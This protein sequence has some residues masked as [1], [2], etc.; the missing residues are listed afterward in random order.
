MNYQ[1]YNFFLLYLLNINQRNC[2]IFLWFM[3]S[4]MR[5][6]LASN[7][8]NLMSFKISF[9]ICSSRL[10][11]PLPPPKL[12]ITTCNIVLPCLPPPS[13]RSV[14][15]LSLSY[16]FL[17]RRWLSALTTRSKRD[18]FPLLCPKFPSLFY[19][20]HVVLISSSIDSTGNSSEVL[21]MTTEGML[22]QLMLPFFPPIFNLFSLFNRTSA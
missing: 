3:S 16:R 18:F 21:G 17:S 4:F 5:F 14:V 15:N 19:S 6:I 9:S 20:F 1:S 22:R 12:P 7:I 13:D 8:P 11:F 2:T 10:P